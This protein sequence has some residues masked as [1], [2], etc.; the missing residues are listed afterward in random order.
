MNTLNNTDII[1]VG[2]IDTSK[3]IFNGIFSVTGEFSPILKAADTAKI[4]YKDI[5][6]TLY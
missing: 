6:N 5:Q 3:E 1:D 2:I 4:K